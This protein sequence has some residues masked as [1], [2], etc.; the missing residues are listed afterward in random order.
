MARVFL[1]APAGW[2]KT[3]KK[4]ELMKHFGCDQVVDDWSIY[5]PSRRL[6]LNALVMTD[7]RPDPKLGR[8]V[9]GAEADEALRA[10][11]GEPFGGRRRK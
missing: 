5:E 10:V 3:Y 9:T 11:G 7:Q 4:H 1:V 6:G 8:I 2:G